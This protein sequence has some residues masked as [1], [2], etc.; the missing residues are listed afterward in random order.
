MPK[1]SG[2]WIKRLAAV[3]VIPVLSAC[4]GSSGMAEIERPSPEAMART[5]LGTIT[6]E[7]IAREIDAL[8]HDS[9]AGR[10]TPSPGLEAAASYIAERFRSMGLEPAGENGTYIDRFEWEQSTFSRSGVAFRVQGQGGAELEYSRDFFLIPGS[11]PVSGEGFYLGIAG[12]DNPTEDHR[13]KVVFL[14][15]PVPELNQEF[16]ERI[17]GALM[18]AMSSGIAGLVL[19]LGPEFP[20]ENVPQISAMGAEQQAPIPLLGMTSDAAGRLMG[21]AG[22]GLGALRAAEGPTALG[23]TMEIEWSR[24]VQIHTPPNVVGILPGSDPALRDTYVVLTAHFDH[25]GIG[26]PDAT[27]DSIYNGADDNASGTAGVL[28]VAEAFASLPEAPARSVIFLAV[29]GEE[30]GLLGAMAYVEDPPVIDIQNVVTNVNLDMIGRLA[31]DTIIGIGQEYSSLQAVLD[32]IQEHHPELGLS[33]IL[34]PVP[35]ERYFF[36]SD[37]LP[38]IQQGIP[39]VFFTTADHEDYHRPSDEAAK[40]DSDKAARVSRLAFLLAYHVAQDPNAPAWTEEG[41]AQ[42]EE[43]LRQSIF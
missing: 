2:D 31:P 10:D 13:G 9:M 28:E 8:A 11:Q 5:A 12:E 26:A 4:A 21:D 42:V 7:D 37:Q 14:D 35:E 25:V 41:W 24:E 34:D 20:A 19:I 32:E 15:N 33:V 39:A 30:K 1:V 16:Q 18:G 40:I 3:I 17:T 6:A 38:F 23:A 36:R 43:L 29:S 27:G 22:H